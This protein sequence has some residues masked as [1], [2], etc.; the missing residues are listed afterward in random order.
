MIN[1]VILNSNSA[2][3]FVET[4]KST[5]VRV[6]PITKEDYTIMWEKKLAKGTM[7][8]I[9]SVQQEVLN[10]VKQ[11]AVSNIEKYDTSKSVNSFKVNG[12]ETWLDKAT[13]VGLMNS[14]VTLKALNKDTMTLWLNDLPYVVNVDVLQQ[15]LIAL[16]DYAIQC[17]NQTCLHISQVSQ[18]QDP[19]LIESYDYTK[20]YPEQL[21]LTIL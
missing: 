8:T 9:E 16:E 12:V 5:Y 2:Q 4:A 17:Y 1:K 15:M 21:N 11:Q 6:F 19:H 7:Q 3:E 20:G 18:M 13:R 10:Y 14:V